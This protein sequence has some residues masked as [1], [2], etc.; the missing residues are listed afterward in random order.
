MPIKVLSV[1]CYPL[2]QELLACPVYGDARKTNILLRVATG[3]VR[4]RTV[5]FI[6]TKC[7]FGHET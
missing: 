1:M 4:Q 7:M 3:D 6:L 5:S 2:V